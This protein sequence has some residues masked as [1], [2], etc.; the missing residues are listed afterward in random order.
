[1]KKVNWEVSTACLIPTSIKKNSPMKKAH[2]SDSSRCTWKFHVGLIRLTGLLLCHLPDVTCDLLVAQW[3]GTPFQEKW[4]SSQRDVCKWH[5]KSCHAI[6][7]PNDGSETS[8]NEPWQTKQEAQGL[9]NFLWQS[10]TLS[11]RPE[12]VDFLT[13]VYVTRM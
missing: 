12:A 10:W 5:T 3:N 11:T 4:G 13:S 8:N 1:M 9:R 6:Y 2:S 7:F